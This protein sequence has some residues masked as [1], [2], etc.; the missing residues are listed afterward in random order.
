MTDSHVK[1]WY[2]GVLV[3]ASRVDDG[4]EDCPLVDLKY[5]LIQATDHESAYRRALELGAS[6]A[7]GYKN[8]GGAD[9]SWEFA[10]L[11]DLREILD[12]ELR[13]GVEVFNVLERAAPATFIRS[14]DQ[15]EVFWSEANK[16]RTAADILGE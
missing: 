12:D 6:E 9:V 5:K 7:H 14:K 15:L 13:D 2:V 8:A 16:H 11:R 1:K 3:V 10:G 4:K